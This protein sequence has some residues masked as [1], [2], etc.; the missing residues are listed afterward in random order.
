MGLGSVGRAK[1]LGCVVQCMKTWF[2][3]DSNRALGSVGRLAFEGRFGS[4]GRRGFEGR[5]GSVARA[6]G[7]GSVGTVAG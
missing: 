5:F 1:G 4:V 6:T 2:C 3:G 7:L